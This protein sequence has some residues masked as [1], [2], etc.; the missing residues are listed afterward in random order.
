ME[1]KIV[2]GVIVRVNDLASDKDKR[3]VKREAHDKRHHFSIDLKGELL[4]C[5]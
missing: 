3:S 5:F 2:N 1:E 4:N